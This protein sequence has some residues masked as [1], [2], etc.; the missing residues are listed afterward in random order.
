M[1]TMMVA[2]L[3]LSPFGLII[4][5]FIPTIT[6]VV[7]RRPQL[8][9]R[10]LVAGYIGALF[11]L[12]VSVGASSYVSPQ[13]AVWIW[14]IPPER[15]WDS[16]VGLFLG[17]FV[18]AAFVSIV[19]ISFVGIPVLVALSNSGRATAPWLIISSAVISTVVAIIAYLIMHSSFDITFLE[20]LGLLLISHSILTIGFSL[21]ARLPWKLALK[22]RAG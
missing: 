14:H 13:D 4:C 8:S 17:T 2:G 7:A 20:T 12:A 16:L 15:Y 3:I 21:A 19:G 18:V 6:I 5:I 22:P 1:E 9:A 10:R 11:A